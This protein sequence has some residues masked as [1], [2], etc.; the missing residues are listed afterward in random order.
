MIVA[1]HGKG[2][3]LFPDTE[4]P[5]YGKKYFNDGWWMPRYAAW[6]SRKISMNGL[7]IMELF[8]KKLLM[9]KMTH[10]ANI[11]WKGCVLVSMVEV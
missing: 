4:H 1:K 6:F 11:F 5:D 9:R 10:Q 3:L 2:Y 8:V 7:L